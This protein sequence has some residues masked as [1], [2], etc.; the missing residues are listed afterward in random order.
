MAP[1]SL[2][3]SQLQTLKYC[4]LFLRTLRPLLISLTLNPST[5]LHFDATIS[6]ALLNE[7]RLLAEFPEL[8]AEMEQ[9]K[10]GGVS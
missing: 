6:L 7:S 9:W 8:A 3:E 5:D 10:D 4:C 1:S 2:N